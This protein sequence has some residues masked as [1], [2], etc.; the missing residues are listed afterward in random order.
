[1]TEHFMHLVQIPSGIS[2]LRDFEVPIRGFLKGVGEAPG[3]G[4]GASALGNGRF[5]FEKM[6]AIER[7]K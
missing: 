1:M 5:F 7:F 3:L 4:G 6:F 2:R